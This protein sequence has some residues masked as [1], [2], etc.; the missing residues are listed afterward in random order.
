M[1]SADR[2]RA[3]PAGFDGAG[4][5]PADGGGGRAGAA[6]LLALAAE[7]DAE[8][9]VPD[10]TGEPIADVL[11]ALGAL[12][13][14]VTRRLGPCAPWVCRARLVTARGRPR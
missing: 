1:A 11:V 9:V 12:A 14:A 10:A 13:D 2:G 6:V 8:L 5:V 4:M 7:A 3:G